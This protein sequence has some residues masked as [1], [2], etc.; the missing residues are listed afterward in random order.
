MKE[1]RELFEKEKGEAK[2]IRFF[3]IEVFVKGINSNITF[4]VYLSIILI[5]EALKR[6]NGLTNVTITEVTFK[7]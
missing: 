2:D 1:E 5:I 3:R 6:T 7:G 4:T